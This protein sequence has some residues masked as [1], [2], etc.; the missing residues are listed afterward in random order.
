MARNTTPTISSQTKLLHEA[1][2]AV[3]GPRQD[4]HGNIKDNFVNIA[5][6]WSLYLQAKYGE[7]APILEPTDVAE[8]QTLLKLSRRLI[9]Q[10]IY[11][12]YMDSAGYIAI[13]ASLALEE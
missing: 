1:A 3:G 13:A 10:P 6:F 7:T 8:M 9:G 2:A 12:H 5:T 11:D 4:T